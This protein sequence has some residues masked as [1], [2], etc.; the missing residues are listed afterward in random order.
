M[1]VNVSGRQVQADGFVDE[2]SRILVTTGL[3]P[4]LLL[5]EFTESV[6]MQDTASTSATL[7]GLKQLGVRLGID[8]FGTGYSSLS[9]LRQFPIDVLKIDRSFVAASSNGPEQAAVVRSIVQLGETLHLETIAEG[10]EE[11]GQLARPSDARRKPWPGLLPGTAAQRRRGVG[12]AGG[13][14]SRAGSGGGSRRRGGEGRPGRGGRPVWVRSSR[15][16]TG[17]GLRSHRRGPRACPRSRPFGV[18]GMPGTM[19]TLNRQ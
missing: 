12:A 2:V 6:L 4:R 17:H 15:G 7:A 18:V 9:Y 13:R 8:D 19:M 3:E 10:I 14:S 16:P 11:A 5:L 1:S